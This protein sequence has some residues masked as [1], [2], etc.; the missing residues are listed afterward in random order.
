MVFLKENYNFQRFQGWGGNIFQGGPTLSSGF[1]M[2]I[3]IETY[4]T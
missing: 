1:Q 3:S 2:L 4:R